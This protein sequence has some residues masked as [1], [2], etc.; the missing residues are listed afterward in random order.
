[1][2]LSPLKSRTHISSFCAVQSDLPSVTVIIPARPDESEVTAVAAARALDYPAD[3]LEIILARG[4]QPLL[5][6][7][8]RAAHRQGGNHLFPRRRFAGAAGQLEACGGTFSQ[9]QGADGWRPELVSARSTI[10]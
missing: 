3:K 7:Q 10:S 9:S 2:S 6:A 4:K 5:Q 8:Y 1:M